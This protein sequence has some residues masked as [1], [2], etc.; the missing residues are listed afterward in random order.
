M[1]YISLDIEILEV[2]G[3][4]PN[5]DAD[6]GVVAE[7]RILISGSYDFQTLGGGIVALGEECQ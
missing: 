3:M 4:L 2:E 5:V 7:E 1:T 6:D